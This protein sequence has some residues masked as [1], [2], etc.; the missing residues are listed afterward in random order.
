VQYARQAYVV[1][2]AALTAQQ[3][4]IFKAANAR[5]DHDR[6]P[7]SALPHLVSRS[8]RANNALVAGAAAKAA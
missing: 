7:I 1:D 4:W 5:P 8:D 6:S 2:V 3:P